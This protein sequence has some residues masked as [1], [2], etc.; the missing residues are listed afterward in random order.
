MASSPRG[1]PFLSSR[2]ASTPASPARP[3]S[4]GWPQPAKTVS[5]SFFG[6]EALASF[7]EAGRPIPTGGS[8]FATGRVSSAPPLLLCA[9]EHRV[10]VWGRGGAVMQETLPVSRS[11]S[12]SLE[13]ERLLIR[14]G[15]RDARA[16]R[17][18]ACRC[19]ERA[20]MSN[21]EQS[22]NSNFP[23]I[24]FKIGVRDEIYYKPPSNFQLCLKAK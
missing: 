19:G 14:G 2:P 4:R 22:P 5:I 9:P 12:H 16:T 21:K 6:H 1:Q 24:P 23:I 3:A 11:V 17:L 18:L 15:P 20:P 10:D 13:N 7:C 8:V